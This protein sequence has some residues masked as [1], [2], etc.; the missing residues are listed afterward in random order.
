MRKLTRLLV[1]LSTVGLLVSCNVKSAPDA[2][3]TGIEIRSGEKIERLIEVTQ[4]F[5]NCFSSEIVTND[6]TYKKI[7]GEKFSKELTL[8]VSGVMEAEIPEAAK[9]GIEAEIKNQFASEKT[10]VLEDSLVASFDVPGNSRTSITFFFRE[11]L[12]EGEVSYTS[13]GQ[14]YSTG[15]S[16]RVSLESAGWQVEELSCVSDGQQSP[17]LPSIG[18]GMCGDGFDASIW[19]P[20]ST[21]EYFVPGSV[22]SC[23]QL[24]KYGL[25]MI[26][27][28]L[29]ILES[30][31]GKANW[32]GV[33]QPVSPNA[34]I[35]LNVHLEKLE[36]AQIWIGFLESPNRFSNGKFLRIKVADPSRPNYKSAFDIVEMHAESPGYPLPMFANVFDPNDSG[37]YTIHMKIDSNRLSI[38]LNNSPKKAFPVFELL[39]RYLFIGYLSSMQIDID[40][41]VDNIQIQ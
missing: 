35:R 10:M 13:T 9:L 31:G 28:A 17:T 39:E 12:R 22:A 7:L 29:S 24:E 11:V 25:T 19:T 38:W 36:G 41:R 8:G 34:D 23:W 16:Y 6:L 33:A 21:D 5:D 27:G 40:V 26:N 32:Y 2:Q 18:S 30:D 15:Y 14:T 4:T 20:V 3:S 37:N 1:L